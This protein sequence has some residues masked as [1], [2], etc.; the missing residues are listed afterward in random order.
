MDDGAL[1]EIRDLSV[2]FPSASG[3]IRVLDRVS[4]SVREDEVLG[5]V[6]ESGSGKTVTALSA[7]RL[8]EPAARIEEGKIWFRGLDLLA[9]SEREMEGIRGSQISMIFQSPRS[10]L[11]PLKSVGAQVAKACRLRTGQGRKESRKQAL[12]LLKSVGFPTEEIRA[13]SYPHQLSTGMCQRAMI[14]MMISSRPK[15]LVADEPTT[16]L[17]ATIAAQIYDL[18]RAIRVESSMSILLI[19]HDFGI[20][21]ENC[22]RV[23]VM[24]AGQIVE[25]GE[26]QELFEAPVH[27]YT[28]Y[29]MRHL[30]RVDRE[31][32]LPS[33]RGSVMGEVDYLSPGCRFARKCPLAEPLCSEI[34]PEIVEVSPAHWVRCHV[35]APVSGLSSEGRNTG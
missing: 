31:I 22:D 4:L 14:A 25:L 21:A 28:T 30:P 1:L 15:L 6:G 35:L 26:V 2:S 29:L 17:D 3:R 10:A 33:A 9:T 27:P 16:A 19:T 18:L 23:I 13:E 8:L 20:V 34:R 32:E 12:A 24:H 11:N 7:L 5:L